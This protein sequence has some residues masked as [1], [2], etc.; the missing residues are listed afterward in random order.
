MGMVKTRILQ[1]NFTGGAISPLAYSRTDLNKFKNSVREMENFF[2]YPQG[3][4]GF[5]RGFQH[6]C[7]TKDSGVACLVPFTFNTQ[8]NYILEFGDQ[9]IRI[10]KNGDLVTYPTIEIVSISI[11]SR[12]VVTY[13]GD[14]SGLSDGDRII[15]NNCEGM[16]EVNRRE[17]EIEKLDKTNMTFR[18]RGVYSTGYSTYI[19]GGVFGKIVEI[20]TPYVIADVFDIYTKTQSGDVLYLLHY[21]YAPRKLSRL[22]DTSWELSEINFK[23]PPTYEEKANIATYKPV[24]SITISGTTATLTAT[25]HGFVDGNFIAISGCVPTAYNDIFQ[26]VS[27]PTADTLTFTTDYAFGENASGSEMLVSG[28]VL[29]PNSQTGDGIVFI[30][31]E[32]LFQNGDVGRTIE[33]GTARAT[34][35]DV[36]PV[37]EQNKV[38]SVESLTRTKNTKTATVTITGHPYNAGDWVVIDGAKQTKYNGTFKVL[39]SPAPTANTFAYTLP[40]KDVKRTAAGDI[41]CY[42]TTVAASISSI[43][44]TGE[45]VE[46]VTATAHGFS[47]GD[48]V[49]IKGSDVDYYNKKWFV[50]DTETLKFYFN[51]SGTPN[52]EATSPA[53]CKAFLKS[54]TNAVKVDIKDDFPSKTR[55]A[56]TDWYLSGAPVSTLTFND[57]KADRLGH[58]ALIAIDAKYDTFRSTDVG[59]FIKFQRAD[60]GTYASY[61]ITKFVDATRVKAE[62][63]KRMHANDYPEPESGET[64]DE[65]NERNPKVLGGKWTLESV[66]WNATDGYPSTST[67][68]LDRLWVA[69]GDTIW[70]SVVGDYE[71]FLTGAEDDDGIEFTLGSQQINQIK[72]IMAKKSLFIGTTGGEWRMDTIDGALTPSTPNAEMDS[73]VGSYNSSAVLT[74]YSIVY[75]QLSGFKLR[76]IVY[77][78][79]SDSYAASDMS[80]LF[81]HF[82]DS[83]IKQVVFLAEPMQTLV[84]LLENG[85]LV[86]VVYQR[87]HEIIGAYTITSSEATFE[88][89]ATVHGSYGDDLYVVVKR[90]NGNYIERLVGQ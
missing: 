11:A 81:E 87:E 38:K 84:L 35:I 3:A 69:R 83:P 37:S 68:F 73:N 70:A 26:I 23:H 8:Q 48:Q 15:I 49:Q 39:S 75:P 30:A 33:Y 54:P 86:A 41:S 44:R 17:F 25:A 64:E 62:I 42:K 2:P 7:S 12:A 18:L 74:P 45:E 80:L 19:G 51:V 71:R 82:I 1:N 21:S 78:F 29:K 72:W 28:G 14:G 47:D 79:A 31:G 6:C 52:T 57:T 16:L 46:V 67:F 76:E 22:G 4:V 88:S 13:N 56:P 40:S 27:V 89:I 32:R 9:Y 50:Y 20:E 77:D 66:R 53:G 43:T 63:L 59:K 90:G 10:L 58:G 65:A 5:R 61:L 34:I 85:K 24:V 55:I 36:L 60:T